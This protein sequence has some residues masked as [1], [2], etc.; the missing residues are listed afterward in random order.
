MSRSPPSAARAPVRPRILRRDCVL[1]RLLEEEVAQL[2]AAGEVVEVSLVGPHASGKSTALAHL[3]A[4]FPD[5]PGLRLLDGELVVRDAPGPVTICSRRRAPD[6]GE[7]FTMHP[8]QPDDVLE[9]L[10]A[11]HPADVARVLQ[12]WSAGP[13]HDLYQR[14]GVCRDV[15]DKLAARPDLTSARAAVAVV[16]ADAIGARLDDAQRFA[17]LLEAGPPSSRPIAFRRELFAHR[18]LLALATVRGV[19]TADWILRVALS[20]TRGRS[21]DVRW[22]TEVRRAIADAVGRDE[23]LRASLLATA[24]KA[25]LRHKAFVHG[26]LAM[27]TN[28]HRP[29]HGLR[30][31]M[32]HAW[33]AGIDLHAQRV[34]ADLTCAHLDG[35][36]LQR[37]DLNACRL[38]NACLRRARAARARFDHV[39]AT[40][41]AATGLRAA[42][43]SWVL[44][45]LRHA[46]LTDAE[47]DGADLCRADLSSADLSGTSLRNTRMG[48]AVL[49]DTHLHETDLTGAYLGRAHLERLDLRGVLGLSQAWLPHAWIDT[50]ELGGTVARG[51]AARQAC[52]HRCDLTDC[53]WPGADLRGARLRGCGLAH[54]DWHGADLRG[55]DLR[56][57]TFHL[58][59][60]RSGLV[61]STIA[62]EGSR[63]GFYTDESFEDLFQAPEA[64]RKADLRDCDLRGADLTGVDFYLVDLRGAKLDPAQRD[65]VQRCRAILSRDGATGA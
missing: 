12:V 52:F 62:G 19:L 65:W 36:N 56:R 44:A 61:D 34:R 57:S 25:R 10:L 47:L 60:S 40:G 13:P 51:L 9:Y 41:I 7:I 49:R 38:A 30:G 35:A 22:T 63:T 20:Q 3:A 21:P 5:D 17:T 39:L 37:A 18:H 1:P 42:G 45:N 48:D 54:V 15:I 28:G 6:H 53:R 46:D 14:P 50:C 26:A 11:R 55:A 59:N 32:Q 58:G 16:L 23:R 27:H 8:W 4:V 31:R 43:S 33:L 29:A 64:V 2:L 24:G